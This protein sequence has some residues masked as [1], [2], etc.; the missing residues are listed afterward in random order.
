MLGSPMPAGKSAAQGEAVDPTTALSLLATAIKLDRADAIGQLIGTHGAAIGSEPFAAGAAAGAEPGDTPLHLACRLGKVD[1]TRALLRAGVICSV[2]NANKQLALDVARLTDKSVQIEHAFVA[3]LLQHVCS[4]NA[5]RVERLLKGGVKADSVDGSPNQATLLHW[6]ATFGQGREIVR[7]LCEAGAKVNAQN[8]A[9]LTPAHEAS[10]HG[11]LETL[12][13]LVDFGADLS[14]KDPRGRTPRDVAKGA[15]ALFFA[16]DGLTTPTKLPPP[17]LS[18][19]LPASSAAAAAAAATSKLVEPSPVTRGRE[20]DTARIRRQLEEQVALNESLRGTI[21][22]LLRDNGVADHV[23]RL[24]ERANALSRQLTATIEQRDKLQNLYVNGERELERLMREASL[25]KSNGALTG[26]PSASHLKE[27]SMDELQR[28][29]AAL[30]EALERERKEGYAA[31]R[32]HLT[33]EADLRAEIKA[34]QEQLLHTVGDA[35]AMR[36]REGG[37]FSS[38]ISW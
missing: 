37:L 3:E 30:G 17:A 28:Q 11:S 21:D 33:Y 2:R 13:A 6:A 8:K 4:G 12:D 22:A 24:Q 38:L 9:G 26:S 29:V 15:V 5:A 23:A 34:L 25:S 16:E 36:T 35:A 20:D 32:M 18:S 1:A 27:L 14:L 19:P 31:A 10:G 7:L